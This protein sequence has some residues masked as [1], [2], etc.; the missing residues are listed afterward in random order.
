[1]KTTPH[2]R[3]WPASL[4]ILRSHEV[5]GRAM[6]SWW[7]HAQVPSL[8]GISGLWEHPGNRP[9]GG[10]G[11]V[12]AIGGAEEAQPGFGVCVS[13]AV[14]QLPTGAAVGPGLR[15]N[16]EWPVWTAVQN[17][18]LPGIGRLCGQGWVPAGGR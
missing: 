3:P 6:Q 9:P 16:V 2:F 1:M 15:W 12:W 7:S 14:S 11:R 13:G 8:N 5:P 18:R 4:S 17:C 10:T